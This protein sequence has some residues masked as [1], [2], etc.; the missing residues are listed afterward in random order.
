MSLLSRAASSLVSKLDE[1]RDMARTKTKGMKKGG[2]MSMSGVDD[3]M[4][5]LAI[6]CPPPRPSMS[7]RNEDIESVL[8]LDVPKYDKTRE[9]HGLIKLKLDRKDRHVKA[10]DDFSLLQD[11]ISEDLERELLRLSLRLREELEEIDERFQAYYKIIDQYD[12]LIIKSENDLIIIRNES[13]Q[14]IENRSSVIEKFAKELDS[15]EMKRADVTGSEL[16]KLVDKLVS[17][18]H[19]LPDEVEHIE[20]MKHLI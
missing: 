10:I 7:T 14:K 15:L 3:D 17:I 18:A 4:T 6:Y 19:N 20:R 8:K 13:I 2:G 11:N 5:E 1:S 16:R 9:F 12:Y